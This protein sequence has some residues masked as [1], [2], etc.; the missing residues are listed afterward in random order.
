MSRLIVGFLSFLALCAAASGQ[1]EFTQ[2]PELPNPVGLGGPIAGSSNGALIVAGG[3]NFPTPLT[4]GGSKVW[5]DQSYVLLRD[6]DHWR[7]S[8]PLPRALAYAACVNTNYGV[9][10]LGGSDEQAVYSDCFLMVWDEGTESLQFQDL[11]PLPAASAFGAVEFIGSTLYAFGGKQSK[12]E[13]DLSA[14][15][16]KLDLE[17]CEA[18]W[19]ILPNFPG[20]IRTKM[21]TAVQTGPDGEPCLFLFS[22]S[23]TTTNAQGKLSFQLYTDA[24]RFSPHSKKWT[25]LADLPA[26]DDPRDIVGKEKFAEQAWPINAGS[27]HAF[28]KNQILAFS[29]STGRYILDDHGDLVP[30]ADRPHFLNRVLQ[31]DTVLDQWSIAGDMP[32][33]V[34]TTQA[35][36][37]GRSIVIPSGE[38]KPGIRTPMVQSI[39]LPNQGAV[40]A[41]LDYA[42]LGI[43][44]ALMVAIGI[45]FARR[46]K[47]TEDFFLG[48]RKIPWWAAGL[49]IF[50][51]QLSAITFM[52]IPATAYGSDWRRF[53][54]S[55][56][57]LPVLIIVIYCFLPFFRRLHITTAYE[58]LQAR[59]SRSIRLIASSL[60]ILFQFGRMGIVLLLPAIALSAVTGMDTYLCIA[61]MGVLATIYTALGG[62]SAVIW[63]DVLQVVVLIG[64]A[65]LCLIVAIS[66]A[67]GVQQSVEIAVDAH[68]F[69]MLDWQWNAS[70]MVAW[71]L[72]VGFFF[73]NLVPYTTDQTVIQRYLTTRDEKAAANSLWLNLAVTIPTGLL[74]YGLGTALFAYYQLHPMEAALIPD[75]VDQLVPWFVVTHLPAGIAGLIVAGI[76]A[77]AMS[78]LD[79]SMN[80]ITTSVVSDFIDPRGSTSASAANADSPQGQHLGLARKLT[81]LLGIIG[82]AAAMILATYE[83][84]Y[85]FDFFQ[86]VVGLFGGGVA[87]VFI[88]AV[89]TKRANATGAWAG[90]LAGGAATLYVA[91][92]TEIN[93]LLYAAIGSVL[94]VVVGYSV[95]LLSGGQRTELAG[96]TLWTRK[97]SHD[98]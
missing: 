76:F 95:S 31:Y 89:F 11:P 39:A 56:M 3:A 45:Y 93:F 38:V 97:V 91:F 33:G 34:V 75:K 42:V 78:S 27:A 53:M 87:G 63:T 85:L 83:I 60:F 64:G 25:P 70:D 66:D 68:K 4:E 51:T 80:S 15:F 69:H 47:T 41:K 9:A 86:K 44:L 14:T 43:Y 5:H 82:T 36:L 72:I 20:P 62:I 2:L 79:S 84:K 98:E 8:T 13:A 52:A 40:F 21:V 94:C 57:L 1:V 16:W 54:G 24:F 22:G 71:V 49:S 90:L 50:G 28:G 26:L 30:A 61:M 35:F 37:W 65:L 46:D 23:H 77:A 92:F 55:I 19:E 96:L 48:G 67:G 88:L 59:F 73:T 7:T 10:V 6:E 29:G 17:D 18:G 81:V 74:F 12:N 32:M 58:Y